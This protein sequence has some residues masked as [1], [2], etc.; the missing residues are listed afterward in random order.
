[1]K[2]QITILEKQPGGLL[3]YRPQ[4]HLFSFASCPEL[5]RDDTY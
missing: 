4:D 2:S 5:I 1:M 3:V